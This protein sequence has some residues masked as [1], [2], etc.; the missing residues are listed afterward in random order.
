MT[1]ERKRA[2][3]CGRNEIYGGQMRIQNE[4]IGAANKQASKQREREKEMKQQKQSEQRI[5]SWRCLTDRPRNDNDWCDKAT[6]S[7]LKL[8]I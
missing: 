8:I 7:D 5:N 3:E 4:R 6:T 2:K 1:D